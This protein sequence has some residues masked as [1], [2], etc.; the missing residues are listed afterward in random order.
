MKNLLSID[1]AT[2]ILGEVTPAPDPIVS[3]GVAQAI[4]DLLVKNQIMNDNG[5]VNSKPIGLFDNTV[6]LE[7]EPM[8]I[9]DLL[10][11]AF[12]LS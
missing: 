10:I 3:P 2:S 1:L 8:D 4:E 12:F 9:D 6:I 5:V 7:P 11:H